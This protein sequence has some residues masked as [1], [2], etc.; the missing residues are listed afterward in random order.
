MNINTEHYGIGF[1]AYCYKTIYGD[2]EF[3]NEV[4]YYGSK[5]FNEAIKNGY[6]LTE[7]VKFIGYFSKYDKYKVF[8]QIDK[9]NNNELSRDRCKKRSKIIYDEL[10]YRTY[11]P[12]RI[13]DWCLSV[14]DLT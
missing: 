2:Y 3:F 4:V 14:E 5:R 12:E 7:V 1:G 8:Y 10:I 13:I 9:N 6:R 11:F